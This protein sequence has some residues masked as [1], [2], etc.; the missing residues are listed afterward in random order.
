MHPL[1]AIGLLTGVLYWAKRS[2]RSRTLA[3]AAA[4]EPP[5]LGQ[6]PTG[7][8]ITTDCKRFVVTDDDRFGATV[9]QHYREQKLSHLAP[10][11]PPPEVPRAM[12]VNFFDRYAVYCPRGSFSPTNEHPPLS[13]RL[14]QLYVYVALVAE[15]VTDGLITQEEG[16]QLTRAANDRVLKQATPSD[17]NEVFQGTV[18]VPVELQEGGA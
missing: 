12:M 11:D 18:K 7:F 4:A 10:N 17:W 6:S 3:A 16:A 13:Q 14:M 9:R 15:A 8:F 2:E 1:L 5:S